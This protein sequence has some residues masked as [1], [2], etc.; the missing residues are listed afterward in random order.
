VDLLT[1]AVACGHLVHP[2]TTLRVIDIESRGHFY[3]IHDNTSGAQYDPANLQ[4]AASLARSLISLG[5]NLDLGLMQINEQVWLRP[6]RFP[7]ERALSACT[8]IRLGTTILSANYAQVLARSAD[9]TD[10]LMRALSLYNSGSETR[11][12]GYAVRVLTGEDSAH[13]HVGRTAGSSERA[14]LAPVGFSTA[15]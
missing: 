3:A 7:L 6:I 13:E 1:L 8:N 11:S 12:L 15:P 10:A 2:A 14:R 5:H 9:S 4:Q